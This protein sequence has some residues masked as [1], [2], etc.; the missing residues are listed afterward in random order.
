MLK[1]VNSISEPISV[2]PHTEESN[3]CMRGEE[4]G[5]RRDHDCYH[6]LV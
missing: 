5:T 6:D 1:V 2:I 3:G 4:S